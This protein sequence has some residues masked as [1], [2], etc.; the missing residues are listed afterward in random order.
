MLLSCCE[1]VVFNWKNRI[2]SINHN[3]TCSTETDIKENIFHWNI[4]RNVDLITKNCIRVVKY[5][6][7]NI[8]F[9]VQNVTLNEYVSNFIIIKNIFKN[10]ELKIQINI[11]W[12]LIWFSD[13]IFD[14]EAELNIACTYTHLKIIQWRDKTM[15]KRTICFKSSFAFVIIVCLFSECSYYITN[16]LS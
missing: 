9:L 4:C 13:R 1:G 14:N 7:T 6:F 15:R 11:F 3:F 12:W 8:W 16:C 10:F 2:E 5:N